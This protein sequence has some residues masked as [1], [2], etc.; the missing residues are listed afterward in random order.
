MPSKTSAII[1]IATCI[2]YHFK[3]SCRTV[4]AFKDTIGLLRL[5]SSCMSDWRWYYFYPP[6]SSPS[7]PVANLAVRDRGDKG[8]P[9]AS[10][11]ISATL[12][13]KT[14][15]R[16]EEC[17]YGMSWT[18]HQLCDVTICVCLMYIIWRHNMRLLD[19]YCVTSQYLSAWCILCDVTIWV[20]LMYMMWRYK[21]ICVYLMYIMW[22]HNMCLLDVY[23]VTS[24]YESAWCILCYVTN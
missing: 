23:Y 14:N 4:A 21:L 7:A 22:R 3:Y 13:E 24:R 6:P 15:T 19:V 2:D 8:K 18:L 20:C 1:Y 9:W 10:L 5:S 12:Q 16:P 17:Y 11:P